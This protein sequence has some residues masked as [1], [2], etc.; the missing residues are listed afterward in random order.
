MKGEPVK[1]LGRGRPKDS[2]R[3][4]GL[5]KLLRASYWRAIRRGDLEHDPDLAY[6]LDP[7]GEALDVDRSR[8]DE[9]DRATARVL[10]YTARNLRPGHRKH[11][12][13]AIQGALKRQPLT[14]PDEWRALTAA[15]RW[16]DRRE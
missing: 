2:D 7:N 11:G 9:V 16:L 14:D 15:L 3:T 1:L 8:R 12:A 10:T 6:D 4:R 13:R 5:K